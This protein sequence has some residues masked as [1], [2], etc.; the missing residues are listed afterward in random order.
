MEMEE[1]K[2]KRF[3]NKSLKTKKD[4]ILFRKELLKNIDDI[5]KDIKFF[6]SAGNIIPNYLYKTKRKYKRLLYAFDEYQK[7]NTINIFDSKYKIL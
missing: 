2:T 1:L 7:D 6:S 5:K 4:F 3:E